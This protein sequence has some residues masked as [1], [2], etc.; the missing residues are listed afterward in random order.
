MKTTIAFLLLLAFA[1]SEWL[2]NFDKAKETA[3]G[4]HK[5][6]LLNFSGSD[7]CAPCIKMKKEVFESASF[8]AVAEKQL[9]LLRADF[10][11]SKKNKLPDDQTKHNEALAEKYNPTGKFPFTVLLDA[12]GKVLK[13]WDGYV[14]ASQDKFM[15]SLEQVLGGSH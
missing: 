10:P 6:I 4:Q 15:Q 1:P 14:F 3:A 5:Y 9:V 2:V 11:R 8:Q 7:W 12:N 13:E